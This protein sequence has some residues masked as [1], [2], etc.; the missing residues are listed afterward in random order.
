MAVNVMVMA[1]TQQQHAVVVGVVP[2]AP[3]REHGQGALGVTGI[4]AGEDL[5][6]RIL[7][8]VHDRFE[9][10]LACVANAPDLIRG[11]S[12]GTCGRREGGNVAQEPAVELPL[13][14]TRMRQATVMT[15]PR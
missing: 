7:L 14:R 4:V 9:L 3:V 11:R 2:A 13:R 12:T 5:D 6:Q 1:A 15:Q 10:R 8:F